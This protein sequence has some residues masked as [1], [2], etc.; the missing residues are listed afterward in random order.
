MKTLKESLFDTN[1]STKDVGDS[2]I[3]AKEFLDG[4]KKSLAKFK[5]KYNLSPREL[6]FKIRFNDVVRARTTDDITDGHITIIF[7]HE[8]TAKNGAYFKENIYMSFYVTDKY[9]QDKPQI[10]IYPS[11]LHIECGENPY[12]FTSRHWQ[13]INNFYR[14]KLFYPDV[15]RYHLSSKTQSQ[16]YARGSEPMLIDQTY[17]NKDNIIDYIETII[18]GFFNQSQFDFVDDY[19]EKYAQEPTKA[20]IIKGPILTKILKKIEK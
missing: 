20:N 3:S 6:Q 8:Y 15:K 12:S 19:F 7:C 16:F 13:N 11:R 9:E 17:N 5:S 4:I 2:V 1:L 10:V 14:I 18:K